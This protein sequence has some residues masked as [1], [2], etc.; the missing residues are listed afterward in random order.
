M[1]RTA[2]Y[3][4]ISQDATGQRAGVTRQLDDCQALAD[5]LG[6]TVVTKYDDND[7][8]AFGARARPGFE[9]ML[10]AVKRG[11]LDAIICWHPDRL[12][13]RVKD[14][15]RLVDITR[16][17]RIAS[18]NGGEI[19]LSNATGRMLATI[20]GSVSE[21]ESAHKGERRRAANV[22]RAAGLA[23]RAD[24]ARPFGYTQH[25][26]VLEPEAAAVKQAAH[27]ILAGASLRSVATAW[28]ARGLRT[29][30]GARKG[31][32]QW[33]NL[34]LRRMLMRPVYAGLRTYNGEVLA[35]RGDWEPLLD[36]AVWRGLVALLTD[37]ARRPATAFERRA[38]LSG[39]ALCG[40]C[41]SPLYV[42]SPGS[43]NGVP[44]A[45]V[46]ACR[47]SNRGHVGRLAEPLD[48][49]VEATV[50][51]LLRSADIH[52]RLAERQQAAQRVDVAGL[53]ATR[54][55]LEERKRALARL[56]GNGVLDEVSVTVE[57]AELTTRIAAI[58]AQITA[59]IPTGP[60][61][62]MLADGPDELQKHWDAASP[63][64]RGKVVDELMTVTV[65]PTPSG[66]KSVTR[67]PDT[68]RYV[69]D[70]AYLDI[71]P[72]VLTDDTTR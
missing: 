37:P 21:Q 45:K 34:A 11:E 6:W 8:S 47:A 41:G 54:S 44:R 13:R 25:G 27:D 7:I 58:T 12:Y 22:Q 65:L 1:T 51:T 4:R 20:L 2:I 38:F 39:V 61:A 14:L 23:W 59:A 15:Q 50:L 72:K 43:R 71:K 33:S 57:A 42:M 40:V 17:I 56:L 28:N 29:P 55:A 3:T 24:I 5:R 48:E 31:G 46:Y 26:Q 49:L 52:R 62:A 19:D 64:I 35:G 69:V 30:Q 67:D 18:V 66:V 32:A 68:G 36:E 9:D 60:T 16:D 10:G 70:L 53:A 63:D